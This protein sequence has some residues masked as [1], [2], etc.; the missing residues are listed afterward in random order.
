MRESPH[1]E[2]TQVL[3]VRFPIVVLIVVI[4]SCAV[5]IPLAWSQSPPDI[6][7][8]SAAV[9]ILYFPFKAVVALGGAVVGGLAYVLSGFNETTAK[10]IWIPSMYGTYIITPEHLSCDRRIRF[11]GVA[12]ESEGMPTTTTIHD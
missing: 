11:V 12:D 1:G 4:V 6:Q 7:V 3:Q 2:R 5:L 8:V 10:R 9:T